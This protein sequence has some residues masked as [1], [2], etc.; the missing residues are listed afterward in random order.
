MQ[1]EESSKALNADH[2]QQEIWEG[3]KEQPHES[4]ASISMPQKYAP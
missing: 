3:R 4:V 1:G 2:H